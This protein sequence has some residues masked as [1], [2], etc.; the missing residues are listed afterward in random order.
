MPRPPRIET[1]RLLLSWPNAEQIEDYYLSIVGTNMFDTILWDGPS[2]AADLHE[3]WEGCMGRDPTRAELDFDL[4]V[5]EKAS[6]RYVGG[7]G[8]RPVN[9]D[10]AIIDL[11]YALAPAWHGRG[12][13]VEALSALIRCAFEQRG[14][15]RIFAT[16]FVGNRASQRV[17]EKL[18][19]TLEGTMRRAVL[20][21]GVWLDEWLYA[22]TRPD[23][24][25]AS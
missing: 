11:G 13:A 7:V 8:L 23:W 15:E 19:F 2:V 14:A 21:R 10:P 6:H 22:V 9:K 12:Y 20:K 18:G 1:N 17:A 24:E 5:I 16:I 3:Y 4:A 25:R